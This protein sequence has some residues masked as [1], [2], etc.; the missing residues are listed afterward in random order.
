MEFSLEELQTTLEEM[1]FKDIPADHLELFAK[2]I[3]YKFTFLLKYVWRKFVI[4]DLERLMKHERHVQ[5]KK[6]TLDT[7]TP[8]STQQSSL[9]ASNINDSSNKY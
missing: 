9:S 4:T 6:I 1:G 8:A 7:D 2:G 5:K 3:M